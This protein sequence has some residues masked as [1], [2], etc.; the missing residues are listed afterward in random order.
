MYTC[1]V[2]C[3]SGKYVFGICL[4]VKVHFM[5]QVLFFRSNNVESVV[6]FKILNDIVLDASLHL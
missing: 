5:V 6:E 4:C 1:I 2:A 3:H